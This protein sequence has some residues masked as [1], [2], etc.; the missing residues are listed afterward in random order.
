MELSETVKKTLKQEHIGTGDALLCAVSGGA[1]SVC[2]LHVLCACKRDMGFDLCCVHVHHGIR[3]QEADEDASFVR[4]LCETLAVPFVLKETD[5][6]KLAKRS[7]HTGIEESARH[8]R[9]QALKEVADSRGCTRIAVAHNRDDQA[10]TVLY[11]LFRGTGLKGLAGIRGQTGRI[12]RP[13]LCVPRSDIE[14]YLRTHHLS[15]REDHT[16]ADQSYARNR[17]RH[18]VLGGVLTHVNVLADAHIA[19]AAQEVQEALSFLEEH[20]TA[21]QARCRVPEARMRQVTLPKDADSAVQPVVCSVKALRNEHAYLRGEVIYR[22]LQDLHMSSGKDAY[23]Q[24]GRV[25][26]EAVTGLC[27]TD[28]GR[29][30]LD[31]PGGVRV[32]R[33]HDDLVLYLSA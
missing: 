33:R 24:I 26:V 16:N 1:D 8:A 2:L 20:V 11:H 18:T 32:L 31:L 28:N 12:I 9:Y 5:V 21:A 27:M 7:S 4:A 17:I 19:D 10:E 29:A 25:H 14:A 15:W 23:Y 13:L 22:A 30:R 3:G 6:P